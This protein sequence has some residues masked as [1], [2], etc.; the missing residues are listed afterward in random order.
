MVSKVGY[1][2]PASDAICGKGSL[3]E[4]S[5]ITTG[6]SNP[7]AIPCTTLLQVTFSL[8][9]KALKS[10]TQMVPEILERYRMEITHGHIENICNVN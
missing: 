3:G 7:H 4:G 8:H 6:V 1:N 10:N 5:L 9:F 2:L